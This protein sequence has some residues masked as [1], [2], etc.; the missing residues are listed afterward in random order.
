MQTKQ[1][2]F[3]E[4]VEQGNAHFVI[5]AYQRKYSWSES[6]CEELWLDI[7]RAARDDRDHFMGVLVC[8]KGGENGDST[9]NAASASDRDIRIEIIDGQQRLTTLT[10]MLVALTRRLKHSGE[11]VDALPRL[12]HLTLSPDDD[13]TLQA[14]LTDAPLPAHA[15][16]NIVRNLGFFSEKMTAENFDAP[17][18]R[19]SLARL[20]VIEVEV[21]ST[22]Q[23]QTIFEGLNS[24]GVPLTVADMVRNYLLLEESRAEQTRLYDEYWHVIEQL[25]APDPGSLRLN[26]AIKGWLTVRLK[27]ARVLGAGRAYSS[28]K[29]YYEDNF[30]ATKE[31]LLVELRGFC[32]MWAESYRFHAV[33]KFKSSCDWAVNGAATLT[34]NYPLRPPDHPEAA[35]RWKKQM[36]EANENW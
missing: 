29:R 34:A 11:P 3:L 36:E 12:P 13:D 27:G 21:A 7:M 18:F 33:K 1:I 31:S 5:P 26:S 10:L 24:K 32:L 2:G 19:R 8:A 4:F 35:A 22:R 17:A 9:H 16:E 6:Q 28:F 25:F 15:S 30:A 14:V 20:F 23:A